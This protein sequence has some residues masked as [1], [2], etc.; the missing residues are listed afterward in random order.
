MSVFWTVLY[1]QDCGLGIF[2]GFILD[3]K[4][5]LNT[6]GLCLP[7]YAESEKQGEKSIGWI[8]QSVNM[9]G[10]STRFFAVASCALNSRR[11]CYGAP[12][13]SLLEIE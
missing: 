7:S 11:D 12:P 6:C 4:S 13:W 5:N 10:P 1:P 8:C 2:A 3:F 9:G